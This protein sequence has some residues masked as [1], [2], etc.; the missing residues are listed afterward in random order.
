[1]SLA[2]VDALNE[3]AQAFYFK[4]KDPQPTTLCNP[5]IVWV[6]QGVWAGFGVI[7]ST[8]PLKSRLQTSQ[9]PSNSS[10]IQVIKIAWTGFGD[11]LLASFWL[12]FLVSNP[13]LRLIL[14]FQIYE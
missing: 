7:M 3:M 8:S 14:N 9:C 4:N 2:I 11:D 12:P 13:L 5:L 10:R 1:M 6:C